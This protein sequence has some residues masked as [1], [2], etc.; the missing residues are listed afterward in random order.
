MSP[1]VTWCISSGLIFTAISLLVL[2]ILRHGAGQERIKNRRVA[3]ILWFT[4]NRN[5]DWWLEIGKN[6][7]KQS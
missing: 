1:L 7:D 4:R 5:T 3:E 6:N 2:A